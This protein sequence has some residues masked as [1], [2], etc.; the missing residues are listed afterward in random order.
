METKNSN[1][2]EGEINV[3]DLTAKY[4][5]VRDKCVGR[6]QPD[7]DPRNSHWWLLASESSSQEFL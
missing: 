3:I 4:W 1:V 5:L 6:C 7:Q 2:K